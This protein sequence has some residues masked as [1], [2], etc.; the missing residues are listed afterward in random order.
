[1]TDTVSSYDDV[2]YLFSCFPETHPL[3]LHGVAHL[4]GL[5]TPA[6]AECRVLELGCA[7][8]GNIVPMAY[9]LPTAK[10]IGIDR[11]A[12]QI[13]TARKFADA[14]GVKNLDLRAAS[15]TEVTPEWGNF[16]Y[17]IAHGVFSW[18]PHDVAEK[19]LQICAE[20]LLPNGLAYISF[21][22]YPGWH[23]RMWAREAMLF[24]AE[25]FEDPVQKVRAGRD[26][27]AAL[28]QSPL[29]S[30]LLAG[31]IQYL[32][33]KAEGY[34]AHEYFESTNQP[35]YF[36]DF[37]ARIA[38]H[39]LQYLGDALQNG[40]VAADSWPAFGSWMGA[41]W[42]DLI[43]REQYVDFVRNRV[44][45]RAL[46]C[47]GNLS[48][49]WTRMLARAETMQVAGYLQE[50]TDASGRSRFD[51]LRGGLVTGAG[52]LRDALRTIGA[53]F[54]LAISVADV[55]DAAGHHRAPLLRELFNC[56]MSGMLELYV[57]P[58]AVQAPQ[59][60]D[61]PRASPV[62]RYLVAQN[63]S[64]VNQRHASVSVD[65]TQRRF[66]QLA[67]GT[68]TRDQLA[69]ELGTAREQVDKIFQSLLEIALLEA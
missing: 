47:R 33:G 14:S 2:P 67:D 16:D 59:S 1:M 62:A 22:T 64:P 27:L 7:V 15:I 3:R 42:D 40:M 30:T 23:V 19:V 68:R 57:E 51:H 21:N 13:D 55:I 53:R 37:A 50:S 5:E 26:F 8:G 45:R 6:P 9:S 4:F 56:W 32:Q 63:Q 69:T 35:F 20:Q 31:E 36:R 39:G 17:I 12:S 25:Q 41:N 43:R 38:K 28:A 24:H 58:P 54:P 46:I 49:E 18:V 44:F 66:I 60:S 48:L 61:K 11:V 52:P 65:A 29:T 10:L 34:L